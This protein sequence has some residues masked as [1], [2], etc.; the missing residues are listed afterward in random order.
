[1]AKTKT[2]TINN[3]ALFIVFIVLYCTLLYFIVFYLLL[4]FI[5]YDLVMSCEIQMSINP[6]SNPNSNPSSSLSPVLSPDLNQIQCLD[7]KI[8]DC[9][10]KKSN[11]HFDCV[12][13]IL[14][15]AGYRLRNEKYM[16]QL[17]KDDPR[18][19]LLYA[20]PKICKVSSNIIKPHFQ[21]VINKPRFN[22]PYVWIISTSIYFET[23]HWHLDYG[24]LRYDENGN[25]KI[26]MK[27]EMQQYIYRN[28]FKANKPRNAIFFRPFQTKNVLCI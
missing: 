12:N 1:M 13:I 28:H 27:I 4:K 20:M 7:E 6:N 22:I 26:T 25:Q 15:F 3:Q 16:K 9:L 2:T 21:V 24:V 8:I 11:H 19:I 14:A 10:M 18:S 23:V 17:E 5:C